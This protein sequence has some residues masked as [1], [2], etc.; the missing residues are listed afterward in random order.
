MLNQYFKYVGMLPGSQ[1]GSLEPD[2]VYF[3]PLFDG[4]LLCVSLKQRV[5]HLS[6]KICLVISEL[7]TMNKVYGKNLKAMVFQF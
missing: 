7:L 4:V 3:S 5:R 1:I 6:G 2:V